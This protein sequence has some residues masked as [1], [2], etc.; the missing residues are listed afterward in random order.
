MMLIAFDISH[1]Q[2][3]K[4]HSASEKTYSNFTKT[5]YFS[6]API[7]IR[8]LCND[9]IISELIKPYQKYPNQKQIATKQDFKE[10]I[11]ISIIEFHST[12]KDQFHHPPKEIPT[13]W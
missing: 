13:L 4:R 6:N 7:R 8:V 11:Y 1:T 3:T 9:C 10:Q 5:F 2:H 12:Q